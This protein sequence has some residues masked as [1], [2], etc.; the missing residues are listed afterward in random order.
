MPRLTPEFA[1]ILGLVC[2]AGP[3]GAQ[4][5][6][7]R[8][9]TET[10]LPPGLA[11]PCM[12]AASGDSDGDGDLDLVLAMEFQ[13]N[14]LLLNDGAGALTDASD[15]LPRAVHDSE[16]V[17]FADFDLDGDPDLALVSEDD[18]TDELYINDGT[19]RFSDAS[20]RLRTDDVSNALAVFDLDG[21]GA[22]DLLIGNIG[23]DRVLIG[24]GQGGF[25]DE[26]AERWAQTASGDE[27]DGSRTQDLELADVDGDGA[28][29]V[30]VANEGQN[31]L[32][33]NRAGR[34]EEATAGRLPEGDDETREIRAADVDGDGDLDLL[35]A[36]VQFTM[37]EPAR[38]YLLLNDGAGV[39][40]EAD[41][42]WF[43]EDGR[44][45]FTVQAVDLDR[46]GDLDALAPSTIFPGARAMDGVGDYLALLNDGAGRFTAAEPG[47]VLPLSAE[48]N[49]FD[50]E[51]ADF[52]A[53]GASD[54]FLCNRA[55][56][57]DQP[58]ASGGL[59]R[60]LFGQAD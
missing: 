57:R 51:V 15:R 50:V 6:A 38:D 42:A 12:D 23:V 17:A 33:L 28:L 18:R 52:N 30:I 54:L 40:S 10:H 32:Y 58:A 9:V 47:A 8:D 49:G 1:A 21:D 26:T 11:G 44:S 2:A 39:F 16:D 34:L 29:D 19:G 48:G 45:N 7:Y 43:A 4:E 60:L 20:D 27:Q 22:P 41:A 25:R 3:A 14:I 24:D 56:V 5:A 59:Q 35:V 31:Q 46:D 53:D 55:S 13:P 37:Q 36:N